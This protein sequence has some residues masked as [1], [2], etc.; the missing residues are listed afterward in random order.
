MQTTDVY[1]SIDKRLEHIILRSASQSVSTSHE[2]VKVTDLK[3]QF[4]PVE[5]MKK[6]SFIKEEIDFFLSS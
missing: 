5:W 2:L 6:P 4:Y 1:E 3:K